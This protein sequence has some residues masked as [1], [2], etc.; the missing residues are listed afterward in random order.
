LPV[1]TKRDE[2]IMNEIEDFL[3]II[4]TYTG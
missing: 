2:V 4:Q 1:D 3:T